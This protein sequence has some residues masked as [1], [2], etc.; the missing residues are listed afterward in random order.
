MSRAS[1]SPIHLWTWNQIC[2]RRSTFERGMKGFLGVRPA[3]EQVVIDSGQADDLGIVLTAL[4]SQRLDRAVEVEE[5][6]AGAVVAD[7]RLDPEEGGD[8]RAARHRLD[9]MQARG[10][11][12]QEMTGRQLDR[13]DSENVL[14]D[15]LAAVIRLRR[16][17]EERRGQIAAHPELAAAM[18]A[19]RI[20]DMGA[21]PVAV[22]VIVEKRREDLER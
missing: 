18:D 17:E 9:P 5:Q 20:V 10:R 8:A 6:G 2:L 11:I 19:D 1:S 15:E 3:A 7:H 4:G 22:P 21:E 12:E 14:D 13:V 16:L